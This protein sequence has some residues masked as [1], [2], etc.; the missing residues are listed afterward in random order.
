MRYPKAYN[1]R[2]KCNVVVGYNT[3]FVFAAHTNSSCVVSSHAVSAYTFGR[4]KTSRCRRRALAID[5]EVTEQDRLLDGLSDHVYGQVF[6]CFLCSFLLRQLTLVS[7]KQKR[8]TAI[9]RVPN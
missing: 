4:V 9:L 1:E 3:R 6:L 5:T 8:R 7:K 2:N